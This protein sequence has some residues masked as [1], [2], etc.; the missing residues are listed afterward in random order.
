MINL[1]IKEI[2]TDNVA[3]F[4]HY[5][6]TTLWYSVEVLG[7]KYIFPITAEEA[8]GGTFLAEHKAI[9]LMRWIRKALDA[10]TFQLAK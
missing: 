3:R 9:N 1:N 7:Q 4:S 10:K 6:D 5:R 8:K 2:V